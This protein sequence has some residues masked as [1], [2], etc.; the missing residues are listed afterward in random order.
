MRKLFVFLGLMRQGNALADPEVWKDRERLARAITVFI[1][2]LFQAL[3][4]FGVDIEIDPDL[5]S[6]GGLFIAGVV[7]MFVRTAAD[8]DKGLP[9]KPEPQSP[10]PDLLP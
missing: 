3:K 5:A 10:P 8:P 1:A 9:R 2:A 4:V 7:W 6:A